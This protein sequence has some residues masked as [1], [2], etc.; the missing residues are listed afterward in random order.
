MTY[1]NN[2]IMQ[3]QQQTNIPAAIG[4]ASA[5]FQPGYANTGSQ[6]VQYWNQGGHSPSAQLPTYGLSY[7]GGISGSPQAMLQPGYAQTNAQEVRQLNSVYA[8][9]QQGYQQ[10]QLNN[11]QQAQPINYLHPH[12]TGYL[13]TQPS[14][15]MQVQ[16]SG[17]M[18]VQPSGYMQVQS[19]YQP[20]FGTAVNSIFSP[21]FAGTNIQEVQPR[22][23]TGYTGQTAFTSNNG[24]SAQLG[25]S[26]F[27]PGFAG[28]NP[29]EVRQLNQ[30][31]AAPAGIM[32]SGYG[33]HPQQQ[34][35]QQQQQNQQSLAN[36]GSSLGGTQSIYSPGFAGA[37][38]QEVRSLNSG[39]QA[40]AHIGSIFP[41]SI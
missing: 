24:Y 14:G 35:Q 9:P 19:T 11:Y 15:Y 27:S 16:P 33:L 41:G 12:Q 34:Q 18:H 29:Q 4:Q 22:N 5:M 38:V 2:N 25:G 20:A 28:T 8:A 39:G 7:G 13:Q 3:S 36:Y 1:N 10:P 40:P 32:S 23:Q 17:Y 31:N 37:N 30:G 26:I 6:E 21:G